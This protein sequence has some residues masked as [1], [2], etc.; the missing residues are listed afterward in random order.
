MKT[1]MHASVIISA[2][3]LSACESARYLAGGVAH[4]V[5]VYQDKKECRVLPPGERQ[6]CFERAGVSYH[7]SREQYE[8]LRRERGQEDETLPDMDSGDRM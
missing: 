2:L 8:E 3:L 4:E 6:P 5:L 1:L 7:E